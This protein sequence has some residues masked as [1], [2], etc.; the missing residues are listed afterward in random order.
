MNNLALV[1]ARMSSTRLPGKV[2]LKIGKKTI[3][4]ILLSRLSKSRKIDKIVVC[5]SKNKNDDLIFRESKRL[6][7]AIFRGSENN[8]LDRFY[9][10]AKKYKAKNIIRITGDCPLIDSVE[11]DRLIMAH[12]EK[13]LD[14]TSNNNPG[15]YPDGLD[16]EIFTMK[17][18]KYTWL[19]S[20]SD[21]DK[22]HVTTYIKR[23]K[24]F[25]KFNLCCEKNLSDLRLTLDYPKDF[26]LIKKIIN[27]FDGD[28]H[29]SLK[30]LLDKYNSKN[31]IYNINSG[32]RRNEGSEMN[33]N[34]KLWKRAKNVIADGNMLLSKNPKMFIEDLWPTYYSKAK[35]YSI[36]DLTGKKFYDF[37]YMGVGTNILGY[38][39]KEIDN[40][41]I[42]NIKNSNLST[43]NCPEEVYLAE[44]LIEINPWASKVKF[45]RTGGEANSIAIRLARAATGKD[46]II[47][48]GYHG[49]HDWYL[50]VN[51]KNKDL[52]NKHLFPNLRL[53]G[54]PKI[55]NNMT[56]SFEYNDLKERFNLNGYLSHE[57][58][59]DDNSTSPWEK[60][61]LVTELILI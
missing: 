14:Y 28:I 40:A 11:V 58:Y 27:S 47:T 22:E 54:V 37:S 8:V 35:N 1:Q 23:S 6:K 15:S 7:F 61:D 10:A 52:L 20:I 31:K 4:E 12:I 19:N 26:I 17:V 45:A 3:L 39:N 34:Q 25:K 16:A 36:W 18:L 30:K 24:K 51:L 49:W 13:K 5:T 9:K 57:I 38:A 56:F 46:K 43:L 59:I 21:Y 33:Y 44:K 29:F 53:G 42:K 50:S 41:V 2:M 60:L 48:C 32:Y 55:L